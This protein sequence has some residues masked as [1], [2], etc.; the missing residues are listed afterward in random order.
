VGAAVVAAVADLATALTISSVAVL[1]YYGTAHA[2]A[3]TLPGRARRVVPVLGL[4]GCA[5]VAAALA[6]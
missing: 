1:V 4:V 3:L 6:L 2:A 5:V